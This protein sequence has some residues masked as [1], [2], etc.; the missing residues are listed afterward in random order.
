VLPESHFPWAIFGRPFQCFQ[1]A[2]SDF[3]QNYDGSENE[4]K[5]QKNGYTFSENAWN[6][7]KML[8]PCCGFVADLL[9]FN[10]LM[11]NV[12]ADVADFQT[13][14]ANTPQGNA[15]TDLTV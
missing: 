9:R 12:V 5:I 14:Y 8:R 15:Q 10:S 11:F 4:A 1:F 6:P 3:A 7:P 2:G 13:S